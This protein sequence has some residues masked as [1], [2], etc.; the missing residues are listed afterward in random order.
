M[1]AQVIHSGC[2][3][4][5]L[6]LTHQV[7]KLCQNSK[8]GKRSLFPAVLLLKLHFASLFH[9]NCSINGLT[10]YVSCSIKNLKQKRKHVNSTIYLS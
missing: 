3:L 2:N 7:T 5:S 1:E 6:H 4:T 10:N 8:T 9:S